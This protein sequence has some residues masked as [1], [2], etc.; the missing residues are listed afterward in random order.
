[1]AVFGSHVRG[2]ETELSDVDI[3]VEFE[4]PIG[5]KQLTSGIILAPRCA[6][7][8]D[9]KNAVHTKWGQH[10]EGISLLSSISKKAEASDSISKFFGFFIENH[11]SSVGYFNKLCV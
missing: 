3:L 1:M 11:V 6:R 7:G 10:D 4:R 9:Y 5:E 2:E 8:C